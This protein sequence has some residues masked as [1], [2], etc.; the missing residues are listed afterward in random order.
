MQIT[1]G[2]SFEII[3]WLKDSHYVLALQ[4]NGARQRIHELIT[5]LVITAEFKD[6][7]VH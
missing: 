4:L 2:T 1:F 5:V 7:A 3:C 6:K